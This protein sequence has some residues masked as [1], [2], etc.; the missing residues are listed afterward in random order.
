MHTHHQE[1]TMPTYTVYATRGELSDR[2][3]GAIASGITNT[4]SR[5]TGAQGFF[6]QVVFI[7]VE[8]GNWFMGGKKLAARQLFLTG[9]VRGG[10]PVEMKNQLVSGLCDL[11]CEAA[12]FPK[13]GVWVYLNE[14]P[15]SH[16][17]EYGY[18]LP[19]PGQEA[20]WLESMPKVDRDFMEAV[21]A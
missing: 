4:H 3:K 11:L 2:Q 13:S 16:M 10:R 21:G 8:A 15:P 9:S 12:D 1:T 17:I 18:V 19:E 20:A 5:V 6:A 7:E 14:L